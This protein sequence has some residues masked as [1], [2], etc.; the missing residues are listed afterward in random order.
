MVDQDGVSRYHNR[1]P[2][3][4][5]TTR[6]HRLEQTRTGDVRDG[7]RSAARDL[8]DAPCYILLCPDAEDVDNWYARLETGFAAGN[9]LL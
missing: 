6:D 1:N 4:D 9:M 5:L 3:S 7:L 2:G 8:P